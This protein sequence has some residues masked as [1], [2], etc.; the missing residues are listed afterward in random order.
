MR[1]LELTVVGVGEVGDRTGW[2]R[3]GTEIMI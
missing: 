3:M 1:T 2:N